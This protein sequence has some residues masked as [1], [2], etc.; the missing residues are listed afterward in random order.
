MG[1]A[2]ASG[3]GEAM[4]LAPFESGPY[5]SMVPVRP[6]PSM[7]VDHGLTEARHVPA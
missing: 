5:P 4:D 3:L 6:E 7:S 1:M 2:D